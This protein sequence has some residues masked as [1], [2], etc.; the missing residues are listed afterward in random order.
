LKHAESIASIINVCIKNKNPDI[1]DEWLF[2]WWAHQNLNLG[3]KD[4]EQL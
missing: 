1:S 2:D 3:S 4:Y